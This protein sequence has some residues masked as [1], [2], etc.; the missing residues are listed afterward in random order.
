[1]AKMIMV[2]RNNEPVDID[3][4]DFD[5]ALKQGLEP[6]MQY[7]DKDGQTHVVR[8]SHQAKAEAAGLK[9]L[10]IYEGQQDA[11]GMKPKL[12]EGWRGDLEAGARGIANAAT[13][14]FSDEISG[15]A[16]AA[17]AAYK[18]GSLSDLKS[19]YTKGRDEYRA[20]EDAA[21]DDGG[22]GRK[23][24]YG[25]GAALPTLAS[26]GAS[27]PAQ[28]VKQAAILGAK[29]GAA[30][31]AGG[32]TGQGQT[33]LTKGEYGQYAKDLALG[34]ALG[35]VIGGGLQKG[36]ETLPKIPGALEEFARAR[37]T[38]AAGG[39][40]IKASRL[41]DRM[42]GG[43][44]A[45]GKDLLDS[46]II[47]GGKT[48]QQILD[49]AKE[50]EE[51]SGKNIGDII[52]RFE[53]LSKEKGIQPDTLK[54]ILDRTQ[55]EVSAPLENSPATRHLAD[56]FNKTY[57]DHLKDYVRVKDMGP[58]NPNDS[59]LGFKG[60]NQERR[61]LDKTAFSE[62]GLDQPLNK[63][64]QSVRRIFNDE[65]LKDAEKVAPKE[66]LDD[67][68]RQNRL[69]GVGT[70]AKKLTQEQIGRQEKNRSI[71][72]TDYISG[73]ASGA[74]GAA[75]MGPAGLVMAPAAIVANKIARERGNQLLA[76]GA[77]KLAK[78]LRGGPPRSIEQRMASEGGFIGGARKKPSFEPTADE[79]EAAE[80]AA[81]AK[82]VFGKSKGPQLNRTEIM[83]SADE[84]DAAEAAAEAK[85][86]FGKSKGPQLNKPLDR[87]DPNRPRSSEVTEAFDPDALTE[88]D[89][90][91]LRRA[92]T[93]KS[94][95]IQNKPF[96]KKL[97]AET[98]EAFDPDA[99]TEEDSSFLKRAFSGYKKSKF[100]DEGGFIGGS[101]LPRSY[102]READELSNVRSSVDQ[103]S[104]LNKS[105]KD[106]GDDV[107][108]QAHLRFGKDY[109]DLS[110]KERAEMTDA[111][112]HE[113]LKPFRKQTNGAFNTDDYIPPLE[114]GKLPRNTSSFDVLKD[115]YRRYKGSKAG[116]EGGFIGRDPRK[117][118]Q[119][120]EDLNN[121]F[122]NARN[123]QVEEEMSAQNYPK[124]N[125]TFVED[126][127]DA[128]RP[129]RRPQNA[130]FNTDDYVPAVDRD[131]PQRKTYDSTYDLLKDKF[132]TYRKSKLGD[133]GG[134]V[135]ERRKNPRSS[136][137][138]EAFDPDALTEE[139]AAFLRRA[140]TKPIK[141]PQLNRT[142]IMQSA[143]ELD[144]AEAAAEAKQLF[145]KSKGPQLNKTE[146]K[147]KPQTINEAFDNLDFEDD[148]YG[149]P[150]GEMIDGPER[151]TKFSKKLTPKEYEKRVAADEAEEAR[152]Y[153]RE[154]ARIQESL[155]AREELRD[156][157]R[158]AARRA[159]DRKRK[160]D[161]KKVSQTIDE[162]VSNVGMESDDPDIARTPPEWDEYYARQNKGKSKIY[163]LN[164]E[165]QD[166]LEQRM[167]AKRNEYLESLEE[168]PRYP[169][170]SLEEF[171][172]EQT[173]KKKNKLSLI[174]GG[175][176]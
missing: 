102:L 144:A 106:F 29:Y 158:L 159:R 150:V 119:M 85:Q 120:I 14:G 165:G 71:S 170:Q 37:A 51:A 33:D 163:G 67:Y 169:G 135:G 141:G 161:S 109:K 32:G 26:L 65:L 95:G 69:F 61:R 125:R 52:G 164:K 55:A 88:E 174:L 15:A 20:R 145:G 146:I 117:K 72:L 121:T 18:K 94:R 172:R 17:K 50:V 114:G 152:K 129:D 116:G 162:G 75:A 40:S 112:A 74:A 160:L 97:P 137:V 82:G 66:L 90:A 56:R 22:I 139:D 111:K 142:E 155:S 43:K 143:D 48:R 105:R 113:A 157:E 63:E 147:K 167:E 2:T 154:E 115:M 46:G 8:K 108:E 77:D 59:S 140:T 60:L 11:A 13:L 83:Q 79:L 89:A 166:R 168:K 73:G 87:R 6:A 122:K 123:S 93:E 54:R 68:A 91:F 5:A 4:K 99:L 70:T 30:G 171:D 25:A 98:T 12:S 62:T 153:A 28:G 36:I 16:Q 27:L 148:K 175:K 7:A 76:G 151:P 81:F 3:D 173:S 128:L 118:E 124:S 80:S 138:T 24:A 136:E 10:A 42:P 19:D 86:L 45:F 104:V 41:V 132:D 103:P 9:P 35:G 126:P 110:V 44:D 156:S 92:T 31:A 34:G 130:G 58:R 53:S 84:L 96:S 101:G 133:E 149:P 23:I 39:D 47:S 176:K 134:F 100:G 131:K 21:W 57:M 78:F 49:K 127:N 1:M 38:K 64:L 107:N